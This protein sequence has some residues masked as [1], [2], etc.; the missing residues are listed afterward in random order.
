MDAAQAASNQALL[1]EAK[2]TDGKCVARITGIPKLEDAN[3]AGKAGCDHPET[4]C[5]LILTEGDSAKSLAMAGRQVVGSDRYGV[6]P[7]KG[8]SLNVRDKDQDTINANV[9]FGHIKKIAG[10]RE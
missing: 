3:L 9:E 6:Y 7:L 8:K 1:K 5:T 10:L 4:G 2:K